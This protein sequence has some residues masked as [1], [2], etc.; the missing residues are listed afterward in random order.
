MSLREIITPMPVAMGIACE[1]CG[2]MYL[3]AHPH[4]AHRIRFDSKAIVDQS[5]RLTCDCSEVRFF[6]KREVAPYR[7]SS[8][9]NRRGYGDREEYQQIPFPTAAHKRRLAA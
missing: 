4:N 2:R 7:I 6:H 5:Y 1:L 9:I 8:Y 3:V